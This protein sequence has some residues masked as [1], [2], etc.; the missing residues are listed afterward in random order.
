[1]ERRM[2]LAGIATSAVLVE[3]CLGDDDEFTE[4]SGC[5][6]GGIANG[7]D[8]GAVEYERCPH[9][10][11]RVSDLPSPA[12]AEALAAIED[13]ENETDGGPY[14]PNVIA[15]DEAYLLHEDSYYAVELAEAENGARICL[16]E[17][18]PTFRESVTLENWMDTDVTVSV[19]IEHEETNEVLLEETVELDVDGHVTLNDEVDFPYGSYHAEFDGDGLAEEDTWETSWKLN[20]AYETGDDYPVQLDGHGV[21]LDPVARNSSFGPCSWDDD[22]DVS[23]GHY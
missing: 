5:V 8:A 11:V 13:H 21:F 9:R 15:I 3:G 16:T 1:M 14:L 19:R 17:T 6:T 20:W 7:N 18:L 22:D 12:E 10:I 23:T 2:V 4:S